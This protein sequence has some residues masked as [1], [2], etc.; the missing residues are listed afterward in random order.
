MNINFLEIKNKLLTLG[1][2]KI[3]YVELINLKTL[4]KPKKN[5][6]KFNLFFAF[7]IG[8]VRIIDNI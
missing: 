2:K 5:K 7:Y 8:K 6:I 1:V 4:K 3:D